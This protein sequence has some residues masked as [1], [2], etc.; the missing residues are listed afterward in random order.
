MYVY[1]Y[2]YGQPN[3]VTTIRT[4]CSPSTDHYNMLCGVAWTAMNERPLRFCTNAMTSPQKISFN[5]EVFL[6]ETLRKTGTLNAKVICSLFY[7]L[8]WW[9]VTGNMFS[10]FSNVNRYSSI[11]C[12]SGR[13]RF[14]SR[15]EIG[16]YLSIL[17]PLKLLF[18]LFMWITGA[19]CL[20]VDYFRSF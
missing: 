8:E 20:Q 10:S 14:Y 12:N 4:D 9:G 3:F 11:R 1:T 13:M 18:S 5:P 17:K 6:S 2:I 15:F 19:T 7:R 16:E